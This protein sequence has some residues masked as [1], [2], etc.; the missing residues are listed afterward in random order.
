MQNQSMMTPGAQFLS[1]WL[2][3]DSGTGRNA[4]A[5][6]G[7]EGDGMEKMLPQVRR[8]PLNVSKDVTPEG[9]KSIYS[10]G[11]GRKKLHKANGVK[12]QLSLSLSLSLSFL[13]SAPLFCPLLCL[14][15]YVCFCT[16]CGYRVLRYSSF[17]FFWPT[18][19]TKMATGQQ[20]AT[21]SLCA[22]VCVCFYFCVC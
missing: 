16:F 8:S 22:C 9:Y 15:V 1:T 6:E 20:I 4:V 18:R 19:Q 21:T 12:L 14:C 17:L 5:T 11:E 3:L 2:Q 10:S 13:F 7:T